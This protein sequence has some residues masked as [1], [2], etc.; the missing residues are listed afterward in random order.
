M[1][2]GVVYSMYDAL[3]SINVPTEKAKAV[4]DAMEREMMDK[5]ATKAD[6][7]H[8]RE[9]LSR[10]IEAAEYRMDA[11]LSNLGDKLTMRLGGLMAAMI[12]AAV[13]LIGAVQYFR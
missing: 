2:M 3:V 9:L 10:D 12:S 1:V 6:L 13:A 5:I 11:K 8:A 7:D 4:I